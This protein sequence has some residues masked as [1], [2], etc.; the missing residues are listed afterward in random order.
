MRPGPI[1]R[2]IP[3]I[4]RI[5]A[6]AHESTAEPAV[7]SAGPHPPDAGDCAG[8]SEHGHVCGTDESVR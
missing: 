4:S 5:A 3:L 2:K 7:D 6:P 1:V 8:P